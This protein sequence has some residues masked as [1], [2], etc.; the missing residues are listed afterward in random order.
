MV[1]GKMI[2]NLLYFLIKFVF[3][4]IIFSSLVPC[5]FKTT[6]VHQQPLRTMYDTLS[7]TKST[8]LT[9]DTALC[10]T[11]NPVPNWWFSLPFHKKNIIS[12]SYRVPSV[13]LTSCTPIIS[14]L[15]VANSL[16]A[17]VS[18]HNRQKLLTFH[19]PNLMSLLHYLGPTN[20]SV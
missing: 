12:C 15:Y 18:E 6:L 19:V 7:L 3:L 13:H 8:L 2:E 16:A 14:N 4:I 9:A 10:C 17:S 11:E 1:L 5:T 20:W